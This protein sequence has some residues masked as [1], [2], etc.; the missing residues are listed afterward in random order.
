MK[1]QKV[2]V[3]T[4]L[5]GLFLGNTLFV[6]AEINKASYGYTYI[7]KTDDYKSPYLQKVNGND[8]ATNKVSQVEGGRTLCSWCEN[9]LGNKFTN[10]SSYNSAEAVHMQ[11]THTGETGSARLVISTV[12]TNFQETGTSGTWSPDYFD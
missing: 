10:K 8:D 6:S 11:Y 3:L 7:A 4:T 1:L 2:L 5:V 12:L 9:W